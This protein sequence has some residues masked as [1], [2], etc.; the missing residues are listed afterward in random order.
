LDILDKKL[1]KM[2]KI[3]DTLGKRLQKVRKMAGYSNQESFAEALGIKRSTYANYE[4]DKFNPD[5]D[6]LEAML[7]KLKVNLNWLLSGEG[8][9]FANSNISIIRQAGSI[10]NNGNSGISGSNITGSTVSVVPKGGGG[11]AE[12]GEA[13]SVRAMRLLARIMETGNPAL[14]NA[15]I[16]H[17]DS[18]L[19]LGEKMKKEG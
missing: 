6:V 1:R 13:G 7:K 8:E 18:L 3:L 14:I 10:A 19:K 2:D 16:E 17:L 11:T 9:M 4:R 12:P 15:A 5:S